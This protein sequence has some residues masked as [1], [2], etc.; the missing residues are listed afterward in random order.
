MKD[1]TKIKETILLI[2]GIVF[3]AAG[4]TCNEWTLASLFSSDGIIALSHRIIIWIFDFVLIGIG[5]ILL[6][7]RRSLKIHNLLFLG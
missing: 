1:G 2:A 4:I 7:Y 5:F 3:I 6:I